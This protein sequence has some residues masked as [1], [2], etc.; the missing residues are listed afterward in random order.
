M[1]IYVLQQEIRKNIL[2]K[3]PFIS[4]FKLY[5]RVYQNNLDRR[6]NENFQT[7]YHWEM[8][9]SAFDYLLLLL[10]EGSYVREADNWKFKTRKLPLGTHKKQANQ[11]SLLSISQLNSILFT[12]STFF[13]LSILFYSN[14]CPSRLISFYIISWGFLERYSAILPSL[15]FL[16]KL[17]TPFRERELLFANFSTPS[18]RIKYNVVYIE[19]YYKTDFCSLAFPFK[20]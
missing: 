3:G 19:P 9:L 17:Q 2:K 4:N 20:F 18:H 14:F 1:I 8:T 12:L 5:H 16:V 13:I 15:P 7:I 10:G 6:K 11:L